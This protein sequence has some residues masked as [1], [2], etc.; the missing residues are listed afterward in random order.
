MSVTASSESTLRYVPM[1][2]DRWLAL[3]PA[4]VSEV[5]VGAEGVV[6]ADA[7]GLIDG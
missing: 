6:A 3:P 5:A 7:A 4:P 2:D 1:A